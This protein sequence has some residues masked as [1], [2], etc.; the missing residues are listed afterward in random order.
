[1]KVL[2]AVFVLAC[3]G[4]SVSAA[5]RL[6]VYVSQVERAEV[7]VQAIVERAADNRAIE[8]VA[9]SDAF[10]RSSTTE[11]DGDQA[12]R[13]T[14]VS[15]RQIPAGVYD[16]TVRVLDVKGRSVASDTKRVLVT[17]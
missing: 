4:T 12:P 3:L 15:F 2:S 13:L 7:I 16:V 10:Y 1:M 17:G 8:V 14:S 6:K 9:E 11:L 5:Q